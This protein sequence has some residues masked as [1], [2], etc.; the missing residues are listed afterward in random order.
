MERLLNFIPVDEYSSG[1]LE[2]ADI[3]KPCTIHLPVPCMPLDMD[4][5]QI[6]ASMSSFPDAIIIVNTQ[7][8]DSEMIISRRS[9]YQRILAMEKEGTQVV[10]R[11]LNLR[12]DV[13]VSAAVCLVWYDCRNIGKKATAPN[14]ASSSLPLCVENIAANVLTSL[15]FTF[16]GC[17]LVLVFLI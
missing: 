3:V 1:S 15:S 16:S 12:V 8:V 11:D 7:S 17:I 6:C 14:E 2:A 5:T 10:E 13:I 4:S 9:T